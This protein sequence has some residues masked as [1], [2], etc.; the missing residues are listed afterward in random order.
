MSVSLEDVH[1]IAA[2]ARLALDD[3]RA[4]TLA[5]ELNTV[6]EHMDVLA[7]VDTEG[8]QE[9]I[10]VGAQGR[11]LRADE[12]PPTPLARSVDSIA[13]R[14]RDGFFLVPRLASHETPEAE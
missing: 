6:L 12:G 7:R 9:S 14:M 4:V 3:E 2:L 10:G 11:P 13:P 1:H 5:A 8:V